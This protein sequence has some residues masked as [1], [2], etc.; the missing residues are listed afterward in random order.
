MVMNRARQ[1][2]NGVGEDDIDSADLRHPSK[3]ASKKRAYKEAYLRRHL[4]ELGVWAAGW[5][6]DGG[7]GGCGSSRGRNRQRVGSSPAWG[8][9][10]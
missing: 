7:G 8:A 5:S 10:R 9:Q 3:R 4:G 6:N 2:T 1:P